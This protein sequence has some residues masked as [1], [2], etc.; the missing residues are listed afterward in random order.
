MWKEPS[1]R[2]GSVTQPAGP[3]RGASGQPDGHLLPGG[4]ALQLQGDAMTAGAMP[5]AGNAPTSGLTVVI[6]PAEL[7]GGM[8]HSFLKDPQWQGGMP[9]PPMDTVQPAGHLYTSTR[10]LF[11]LVGQ[12]AV[13][14]RV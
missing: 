4:L 10:Q 8:R 13:C 1:R 12:L 9:P 7:C 5:G 6:G 11:V 3:P 2:R 14:R